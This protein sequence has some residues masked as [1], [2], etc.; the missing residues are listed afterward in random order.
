MVHFSFTCRKF[1][2]I[3][4]G[5]T[6]HGVLSTEQLGQP[7]VSTIHCNTAQNLSPGGD[8]DIFSDVEAPSKV[9]NSTASKEK[10]GSLGW[11]L[12][13][14]LTFETQWRICRALC[15]TNMTLRQLRRKSFFVWKAR[16]AWRGLHD[17][18]CA[19]EE[20]YWVNLRINRRRASF[21]WALVPSPF[22]CSAER[23]AATL[24]M[25]EHRDYQCLAREHERESRN[26]SSIIWYVFV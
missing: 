11:S 13:N 9:I 1:L 18:W 2:H 23:E 12:M 21:L 3:L 22:N 5:S 24:R 15:L 8:L 20:A 17:G 19:A 7:Q 14:S 26:R 4:I 6:S 16:T 10:S 25:S